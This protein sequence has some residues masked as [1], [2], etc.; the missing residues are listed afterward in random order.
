MVTCVT[1]SPSLP[2]GYELERKDSPGEFVNLRSSLSNQGTM[3]FMLVRN[4]SEYPVPVA[5]IDHVTHY[6]KIIGIR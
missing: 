1:P 4:I 3:D 2:S 5:A 6:R